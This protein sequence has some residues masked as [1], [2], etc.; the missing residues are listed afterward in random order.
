MIF[1]TII[2]DFLLWKMELLLYHFSPPCCPTNFILL[3]SE[4]VG[5]PELD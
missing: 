1:Q 4:D 2:T 3:S 5:E